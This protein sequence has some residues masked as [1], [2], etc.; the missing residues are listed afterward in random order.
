P[1][2]AMDLAHRYQNDQ[3]TIAYAELGPLL[4]ADTAEPGDEDL[5]Q[6]FTENM[7]QYR[8][9]EVRTVE[10]LVLTPQTLA[11][12]IEIGDEAIVARY[13]RDAAAYESV[14]RRHVVQV[15]L[16]DEAARAAFEAAIA[17]GDDFTA[18]AEQ[19]GTGDSINDL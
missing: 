17:E 14:E 18:A 1:R 3:R 19:A 16:A 2:A 8:A 9:E 5:A 11:E 7:S 4:F 12:G 15:L 6:F 13:E 10:L